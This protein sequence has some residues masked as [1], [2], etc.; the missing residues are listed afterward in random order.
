VL[1]T[2]WKAQCERRIRATIESERARGAHILL[3]TEEGT[4][5]VHQKESEGAGCTHVLESANDRSIQDIK[6]KRDSDAC[7]HSREH[8]GKTNRVT[9]KTNT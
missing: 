8:K 9:G 4:E 6:R 1:P 5:S 7:S 2:N 3:S